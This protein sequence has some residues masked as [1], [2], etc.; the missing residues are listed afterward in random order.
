M[1]DLPEGLT[2]APRL[3]VG[4]ATIGPYRMLQ[5]V[6]EGGMGEVWLAEQTRP[7]HRQVALKIIKAGMDRRRSSLVS[8][9]SGRPWR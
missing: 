4:P 2:R 3:H 8:R 5:R 1:S 6:G 9:P 7:V